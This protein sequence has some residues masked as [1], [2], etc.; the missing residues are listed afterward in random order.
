M[1]ETT[2][3][4]EGATNKVIISKPTFFYSDVHS[5]FL[6]SP[7][8]H[9]NVK[10]VNDSLAFFAADGN[11]QRNRE[12]LFLKKFQEL[13]QQQ[14]LKQQPSIPPYRLGVEL[15][16]DTILT[17]EKQQ[18]DIIRK[19][20]RTYKFTFDSLI[21]AYDISKKFKKQIEG[22]LKNRYDF[23]LNYFYW[24]YRDTLLAHGLYFLKLREAIPVI[25][26]ITNKSDF[27]ANIRRGLNDLLP[28]LFPG[29][30]MW[31][32]DDEGFKACFDS[33][34][35]NFTGIARDYLLSRLMYRA[36]VKGTKVPS[37]Y[38]EKYKSYSKDKVYRKIVRN[39]RKEHQRN[40]KKVKAAPDNL[41]EV[42]GK[43][44]VSLDSLLRRYKGKY[45]YM[46]LWASWCGPCAKEM[47]NMQRKIEK[48]TTDKIIFLNISIDNESFPWR[49]AIIRQ[50][51][52]SWN[53][54]LLLNATKSAFFKQYK[55]NA[56]PRYLLFDKEGKVM[57]ANAPSPSESALDEVLDKLVL[58]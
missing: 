29:N 32:F 50:D 56:I 19:S 49:D 39:T 24:F 52:Q 13:R 58:D 8:E 33:V 9:I 44:Q 30:L 6:V 55:I 57:N 15:D 25:N 41:L 43:S 10:G 7:G 27:N 37:E 34:E 5:E 54:F 35:N 36:Y 45:L 16:L 11:K 23:S 38:E 28:Y 1:I 31:S 4:I 17:I 46:D 48:Y 21:A 2:E 18:K 20:E 47:P 3:L 22:Y 40:G 51:I 12:L 42:D 14:Q 26:G 53:N